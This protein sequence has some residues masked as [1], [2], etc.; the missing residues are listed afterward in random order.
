LNSEALVIIYAETSVTFYQGT[1]RRV[2]NYSV[3]YR[4]E[5]VRSEG[6]YVTWLGGFTKE[7]TLND[8][9]SEK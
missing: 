3:V 2:A 5:N 6:M 9:S 1:L 8:K 4:R 7:K